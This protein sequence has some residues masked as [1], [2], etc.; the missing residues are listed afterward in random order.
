[1][2]SGTLPDFDALRPVEPA[3]LSR[4]WRLLRAGEDFLLVIPLAA[5]LLLPVVEIILRTCFKTG[6][7]GS[8]AIVQHLTLI[9]GMLGGAVAARD[10]R[11]LALSPVQS[12]LHGRAK[13]A[14]RIFSNGFAT[15]ISF[16][17]FLSSLQYVLDL[18]PLG[19][20]LVY[21]IPV[22]IIQ[23]FLPLGFA[24][25][26]LRLVWHASE[27]WSGRSLTLALAALVSGMAIW[28]PISPEHWMI[29]ALVA[30]GLA[31]LLGAPVFTALGGAA[32]ILFWGHELPIQAVPLKHYSL[33]TNDMLPSIPI[34]TLAGYFLAES[35]ASKRLVRVFQALV[36][37][38]RGG[39]AVVT[40]LVCA[41]FTSFTGASGV[42]ILAL[43]GVLM[44]VLLAAGY[45]ER[46]ALG[47][48]TGSGSLG[49]LFPPCLPLILY[50]IVANHSA[51]AD[52]TIKQMFL[53]G[54]GPGTLLVALT[55]WWG[56]RQGPKQASARTTFTWSEAGAA[57]WDA[58][59]E[60]LIPVVAI[61]SLFCVPT[62][63]EAAAITATYALV[64]AT[65]I[66]RDLHPWRDLPR[67]ITECGLLVGGVLLILGVALGFTHYLVDAQIPDNLVAWATTTVTSKWLFL[68]G[69]NVVLLVVGGLIEIYAAIIVIVPLLVPL[70]AALGLDPIHLGIIFLAN[71]E[72]GFLAPPV[73]LNLLLSSY[74]FNKPMS[75]VT[76]AAL[77]MLLVLLVGVLLITYFPPL[78]TLLPRLFK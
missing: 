40:A 55:A 61:G 47:L 12:L 35:E 41:F 69:L 1:V 59:W 42:T 36:G 48:L 33:T 52:L 64:V 46:N 68:L 72:L 19:K 34:F 44:P 18:K 70:G 5:M 7:S 67:V 66:H 13:A 54:V 65:V 29:P 15:A 21:G 30:L 32:L 78:T 60:M 53:G 17:L 23:L 14:A 4:S 16:F 38:F 39:P 74:R 25:V 26:A 49:M 56:I 58:K 76:R 43:G 11:L 28:A 63:V 57:L 3:K 73:G 51:H 50:T 77:P 62:T 8:S 6:I 37:Q 2:S 71:M 9:V 27:K 24:L 75:E 10:G 31:T 20:I 45:S 22:W